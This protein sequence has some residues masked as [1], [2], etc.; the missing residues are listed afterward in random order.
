M[1][2][3]DYVVI[4][5]FFFFFQAEDGI[6]DY[7]VTGVQTCALPIFGLCL[8]HA[9]GHG[10]H[11]DF[12]HEL[13]RD[14]R[15]RIGVLEVVNQLRQ[16]FDRV[17][18]VVRGRRDELYARR[19]IAQLGDGLVHLVARQLAALAGF[20][21]LGHLDLQFLGVDQVVRG[22]TEAR[23][24]DLLD[25]AVLGVAVGERHEAPRV[26]AALA[27]VA[28]PAD[29]VHRDRQGLVGL[30]ADR[31]EGH[32]A[33]RETLDD[34]LRWLD[35]LQRNRLRQGLD[36]QEATDVRAPLALVVDER[37]ELLVGLGIV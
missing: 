10:P 1:I 6:R 7:K 35:F 8:G 3:D 27:G 22:D 29:A 33:G 4:I 34:L 24:S 11:A 2:Y 28:L 37:R 20:R 30:L 36:L 15:L 9:R 23:R 5:L 17:D 21:A 16:V 12:R 18:V 25:R 19:G 26:L 13:D 31:A 14:V 32:G